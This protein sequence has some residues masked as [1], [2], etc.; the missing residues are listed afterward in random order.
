MTEKISGKVWVLLW[1]VWLSQALC[2]VARFGYGMMIPGILEEMN[3]PNVTTGMLGNVA[4][5][6]SFA[7]V[8]MTIPISVFA[9]RLNP[10]FSVP[11][12]V[13]GVAAGFFM[14]GNSRSLTMMYVS[15]LITMSFVQA[16]TSLLAMVKVKG[17]PPSRMAQVNG[18]ENFVSPVGQVIATLCMAT[19]LAFLGS[20]RLVYIIA[21]T[22]MAALCLL[23][24]FVYGKDISYDSATPKSP[25][26]TKKDEMGAFEALKLAASKKVVW[27]IGIAYPA[28]T[29]CWIAMFYYWPTYATRELGLELGQA[30]LVLSLIPIF[31][32]VGSFT[33]PMITK[34]VGYDK[35]FIWPCGFILPVL[36]YTMTQTTNIVLLCI[37]SAL[38]GYLCYMFVPLVFTILYRIG[39]PPR[40]VSMAV[41][42]LYSMICVGSALGG[43]AV[44]WLVD[45]VGL[46]TG[47]AISCC[48]PFWFGIL[49]M[50]FPEMGRKKM[51]ADQL[52][53]AE[54]ALSGEVAEAVV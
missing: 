23:Y 53:E 16:I 27:L 1:S 7:T 8:F 36:Y 17:V 54:E 24:I 20:W 52:A 14:F 34:K 37:C 12:V 29:L 15:Y 48:T 33:V 45:T 13:L 28:T 26:E 10:K 46:R 6:A 25:S 18:L 3:D 9:V 19:I 5:V 40:A 49:G 38:A 41:A 39:L 47:L 4:G 11:A 31:S 51:E 32:A 30:G 42:I 44:G 43:T 50:F 21:A 35:P 2:F 22:G